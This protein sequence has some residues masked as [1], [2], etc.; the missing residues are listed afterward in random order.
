MTRA[1]ASALA[2]L[3]ACYAP[4]PPSGAPCSPTLRCPEPLACIDGAC[5]TTGPGADGGPDVPL[6][7]PSGFTKKS[8]G[9]CHLVVQSPDDWFAAEL[10]CQSRGAHLVVPNDMT[11]ATA[12]PDPAWIGISDRIVE[13]IFI[14]V[15]GR[16]ITFENWGFGEPS[17]GEFANCAHTAFQSTWATGPCDILFPYVCEYDGLPAIPGTF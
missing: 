3:A 17:G 11:E 10:D 6:T 5:R 4:E 16:L 1:P 2:L 9:A 14:S 15:T 13:D 8:F 12:L 7:C